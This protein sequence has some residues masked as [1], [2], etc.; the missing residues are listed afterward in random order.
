MSSIG[1]KLTAGLRQLK[2]GVSPV[3]A[4]PPPAPAPAATPATPRP[5][6]VQARKQTP[7]P[8]DNHSPPITSDD[9]WKHLHPRR[10]WPD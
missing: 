1:S 3:P 2:E 10:V 5:E 4:A 7:S 9:L 6:P 8:D